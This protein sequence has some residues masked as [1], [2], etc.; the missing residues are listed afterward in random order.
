MDNTNERETPKTPARRRRKKT[1]R[2]IRP[3]CAVSVLLVILSAVVLF[4]TPVFNINKIEVEGNVTLTDEEIIRVAGLEKG[5]NLFRAN[6]DKAKQNLTEVTLVENV[7][8]DRVLPDTIRITVTEGTVG[9]YLESGDVYV[10]I[11]EKGKVIC[12]AYMADDGMHIL[13]DESG[14]MLLG[15]YDASVFEKALVAPPPPNAPL[16]SGISVLGAAP[17]EKVQVKETAKFETLLRFLTKFKEFGIT[18]RITEFDISEKEYISFKHLNLRVEF[19]N[20]KDFDY[21]FSYLMGLFDSMGADVEGNLNMISD[22][23]T[24]GHTAE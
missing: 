2:T 4:L 11:N 13:K 7:R 12:G 16:V 9:A 18:Q 17:G 5:T 21:K 23:Y 6:T 20:T 3:G 8:I 1:R 14:R 10:G 19:G 15:L 22:N 24:Y